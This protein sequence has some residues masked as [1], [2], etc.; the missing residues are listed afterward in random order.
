MNMQEETP[1][2]SFSIRLTVEMLD[3]LRQVAKRHNRSMHGEI[4]T[5]LSEHIKKSQK[6]QQKP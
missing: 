1:T 3:A 5:A 2:K 4:L 6:E